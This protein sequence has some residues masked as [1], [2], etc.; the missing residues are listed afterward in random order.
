MPSLGT[1]SSLLSRKLG[2]LKAMIV[3]G[4]MSIGKVVPVL[5]IFTVL[6]LFLGIGAR[7]QP[8]MSV[9]MATGRITIRASRWQIQEVEKAKAE[10]PLETRQIQIKARLLELSEDA[11][12]KFGIN[13]ERLT[14]V[15]VP[16]G[17][18]GEGTG[19]KLDGGALQYTFY[20]LTAGTAGKEKLEA[21]LDALISTGEAEVLSAPQVSTLSGQVAGIYVVQDVPYLISEKIVDAEGKVTPAEYGYQTVGVVLQVLPDIVGE[22]LVQMSVFPM[23]SR[24]GPSEG[25]GYKQPTFY[26]EIAPTNITVRSGEMIVIGG[27][28]REKEEE[29]IA[30][31]PILSQLPVIGSL[32]K[33]S[34]KVISKT[35]LVVTVEPHIITAR[36]IQ[37]RTKRVFTFTYALA[38]DMAR[39]IGG[40]LSPEGVIEINP[41]EAP[42]NSILV[43]DDKDR[44]KV[45]QEVLNGTGSF[46]EQRRQRLF[47]LQFSSAQ[48]TREILKSL[49]SEKGSIE[50]EE[51]NS[52]LVE[53]GAYQLSQIEKAVLSL[54]ESNR[55][56]QIKTFSLEYVQGSSIV[57]S[58]EKLLSPQGSIEIVDNSLIIKDNN[59]VIEQ[60]RKTI[61]E[62][63]VS[64]NSS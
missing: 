3:E 60:I 48:P 26:R 12:R 38:E 18:V 2:L 52:L 61:E 31:L 30:G 7:G 39:Q 51:E 13:L 32:F 34:Q 59:W 15:M 35:N 43:R 41:K 36:E 23:V 29:S 49:I 64:G 25:F 53:D 5:A 27:L 22:D 47:S 62:L 55:I 17:E 8:S 28:M 44:M 50:I 6:F 45:I 19:L 58:L 42:P 33:R 46:V 14:G 4:V 10:F 20:S 37:G 11:T 1:L 24:F 9:D 21:I 54:E 57:S 63:D 56:R 40:M 16:L